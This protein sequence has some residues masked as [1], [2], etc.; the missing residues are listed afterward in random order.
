MLLLLELVDVT[1]GLT[2]GLAEVRSAG[3]GV[4]TELDIVKV[5]EGLRM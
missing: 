2:D 3:S 1:L 5:T 4:V